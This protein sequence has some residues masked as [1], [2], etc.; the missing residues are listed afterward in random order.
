MKEVYNIMTATLGVP[1]MPD[2][3]FTWE[4]Y[5]TDGKYGK[6]QGTPMEFF[7]AFG[8]KPYSVSALQLSQVQL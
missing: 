6:W 8:T 2:Q 7:R 3:A 1:P 5:D 4:Y